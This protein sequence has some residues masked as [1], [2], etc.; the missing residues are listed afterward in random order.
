[1][2]PAV[3]PTK[4]TNSGGFTLKFDKA[5]KLE[6]ISNF[7][8]LNNTNGGEDYFKFELVVGDT[9]YYEIN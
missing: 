8:Q 6:V 5:V 4:F 3:V 2:P 1:L 9:G 7:A